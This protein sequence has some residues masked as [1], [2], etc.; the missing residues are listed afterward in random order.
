MTEQELQ[1]YLIE[2]PKT[3]EP[4][5]LFYGLFMNIGFIE[6]RT[7]CSWAHEAGL[8]A[9]RTIGY[10]FLSDLPLLDLGSQ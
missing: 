9:S 1:Q 6:P 5:Q 7:L 10:S 2:P 8:F 4:P 3:P